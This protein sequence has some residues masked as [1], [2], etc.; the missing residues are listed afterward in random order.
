MDGIMN[1]CVLCWIGLVLLAAGFFPARSLAGEEMSQLR[2]IFLTCRRVEGPT[3]LDELH[4]YA[5]VHGFSDAEMAGQLM[6]LAKARVDFNASDGQ[7]H[8]A[9]VVLYYLRFFGGDKEY[10]FL[11]DIMRTGPDAETRLVAARSC[12]HM[13]PETWEPWLR[14][15]V[16]DG[17]FGDLDRFLVY[18]DVFRLGRE[19]DEKTRQRVIEVLSEMRGKD[20]YRVNQNRLGGWVAE[21]KRGDAWEAWLKEVFAG[22]G[23]YPANRGQAFELALKVGRNGDAKTRQ[24]VIEVFTEMCDDESLDVDRAALRRWIAELEK[25]P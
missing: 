21:L 12:L 5:Q 6:A 2:D 9:K 15:V 16:A 11:L 24:R 22:E 1:K 7:R 25:A 4:A 8:L 17:R 23:F 20:S 18:E 19:A 13:K 3:D 14:E 10:E